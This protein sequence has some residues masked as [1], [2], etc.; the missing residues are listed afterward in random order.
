LFFTASVPR[1]GEKPQTN[2]IRNKNVT[3]NTNEIH[4]ITKKYLGNT[5]SNELKTTEE[6]D[7]FLDAYNSPKLSQVDIKHLNISL[8]SNEI[9]AV[10][11]SVLIKK[12]P[13]LEGL[14]LI[15][16]RLLKKY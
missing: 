5:Y 2:I 11:K 15:C 9:E 7:T 10:I 14:L 3:E 8:M 12:S 1:T 13:R 6:V 16:T 4:R